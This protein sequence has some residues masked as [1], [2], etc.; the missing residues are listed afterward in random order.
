MDLRAVL[1][2]FLLILP[3][4]VAAQSH[5]DSLPKVRKFE[6]VKWFADRASGRPRG[7]TAGAL[8]EG[9]GMGLLLPR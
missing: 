8:L 7:P 1:F 5:A 4:S 3:A 6:N 9:G 2:S